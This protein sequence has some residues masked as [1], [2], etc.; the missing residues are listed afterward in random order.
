M[1]AGHAVVQG[2]VAAVVALALAGAAIM[3]AT[4]AADAKIAVLLILFIQFFPSG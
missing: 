2:G 1:V 4:E 3:A